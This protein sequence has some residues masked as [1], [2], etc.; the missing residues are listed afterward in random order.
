MTPPRQWILIEFQLFKKSDSA[1]FYGLTT[2]LGSCKFES[3]IRNKHLGFS[4]KI[5]KKKKKKK[6]II[7]SDPFCA[8][9]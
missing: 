4:C 3:A 9:A 5:Y 2:T 7:S 6:I 8:D 1:G